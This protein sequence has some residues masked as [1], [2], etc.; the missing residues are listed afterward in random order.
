MLK[1]YLLVGYR[2]IVRNKI[3]TTINVAGL[4]VGV[5]CF[6]A[7]VIALANPVKSLRYE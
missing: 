2:N 3:F 7:L 5:A 4:A 1:N 6:I